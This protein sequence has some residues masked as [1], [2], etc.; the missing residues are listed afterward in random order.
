LVWSWV[1]AQPASF[2]ATLLHEAPGLDTK[3]ER[4]RLRERER[5]VPNR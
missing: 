1:R 3:F 4:L 5:P 2:L